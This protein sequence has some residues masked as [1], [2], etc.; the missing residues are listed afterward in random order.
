MICTTASKS[1]G[2][3]GNVEEVSDG[4]H[5]TTPLVSVVSIRPYLDIDSATCIAHHHS[6]MCMCPHDG[7][8]M[9]Q[10]AE[11]IER[12]RQ[13]HNKLVYRN[14]ELPFLLSLGTYYRTLIY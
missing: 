13:E 6:L 14:L 12:R 7:Q 4:W 2:W 3:G 10:D 11:S 8:T 1:D 9:S 5:S